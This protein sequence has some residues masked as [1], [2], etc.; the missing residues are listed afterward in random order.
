MEEVQVFV[1]ILFSC[2]CGAVAKVVDYVVRE[3]D[4]VGGE[5]A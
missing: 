5:A 2:A 4:A 1:Q 3:K